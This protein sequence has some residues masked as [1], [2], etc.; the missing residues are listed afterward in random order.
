M[1]IDHRDDFIRWA[2]RLGPEDAKRVARSLQRLGVLGLDLLGTSLLKKLTGVSG[3]YELR[4]TG[5]YRLY[6]TIEN[7][8]ARFWTYGT[9]DTQARDIRLAQERRP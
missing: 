1:E 4:P 8:T 5:D 7:D 2:K 3:L 6:F 9:H